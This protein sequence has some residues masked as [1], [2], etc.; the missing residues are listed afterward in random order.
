L[1]HATIG[2]A[3]IAA[4]IHG[5]SKIVEKLLLDGR[6]RLQQSHVSKILREMK[7]SMKETIKVLLDAGLLNSIAGE[8]KNENIEVSGW[9]VEQL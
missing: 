5:Q 2:N 8:S 9:V 1:A 6:C 3:C 7:G 4:S